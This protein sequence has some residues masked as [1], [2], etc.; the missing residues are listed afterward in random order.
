VRRSNAEYRRRYRERHPERV[1]AQ[2]ADYY[3]RNRD[4]ILVRAGLPAGGV[5]RPPLIR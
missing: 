4:R 1:K 5:S 3:Q 2:N